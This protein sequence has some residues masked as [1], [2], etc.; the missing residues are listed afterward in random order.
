[1]SHYRLIVALPEPPDISAGTTLGD[2]LLRELPPL[3]GE[4]DYAGGDADPAGRWWDWW[5]VGGRFENGFLC[6]DPDHPL[7]LPAEDG[8]PRMVTA[9]PVSLLDLDAQRDVRARE[10]ADRWDRANGILRRRPETETLSAFVL[11]GRERAERACP[12]STAAHVRTPEWRIAEAERSAALKAYHAQDAVRELREAGL[13]HFL[14]CA[15]DH[16]SAPREEFV[17]E[18][19]WSAVPGWALID[20][21]GAWHGMEH[22]SDAGDDEARRAL[23]EHLRHM[24]TLLDALPG[25][26]YLVT[27]DLHA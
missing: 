5:M 15:V 16:Y 7:V 12:G 4:P 22:L 6:T 19:R 18:A 13:T 9:A 26:A 24:N 8:D 3:L 17:E 14:G 1:M 21:G 11:R 25:D 27:V 10:A 20:T 23:R 2:A